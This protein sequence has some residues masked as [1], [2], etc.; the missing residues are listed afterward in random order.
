[1]TKTILKRIALPRTWSVPRKSL[2]RE[3]RA[4][5]SR[6]NSGKD[7]MLTVSLNTFLKEVVFVAQTK[8]EVKALLQFQHVF[9]NGTRVRDE[10]FPVGLFDVVELQESKQFFRAT[11]SETGK[12]TGVEI[13]AKEAKT[14]VKRV[15]GKS[16][17]KGGKLQ[18]NLSGSAN[19]LVDKT[20][21]V[22]GDS[23]IVTDKKIAKELPAKKG[24]SVLLISGRH[25]GKIGLISDIQDQ[26]IFIESDGNTFETLKKF[27]Y[28]IGEKKSE[29]T[30]RQ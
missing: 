15:E 26:K 25:V 10:K 23:V 6:P 12:I 7:F 22:T 14:L 11:L 3:R 13:P 4:F 27:A 5:V 9:V 30:V 19:L 28:V 2:N 20:S 17:L 24:Q 18:L 21:V 29:V 16:V 8:K 1:M